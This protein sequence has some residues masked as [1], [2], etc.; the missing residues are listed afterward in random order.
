MNG[1]LQRSMRSSGLD[2]VSLSDRRP[3][4]AKI[5]F[6]L[7]STAFRALLGEPPGGICAPPKSY[8]FPSASEYR[9]WGEDSA[10]RHPLRRLAG[11]KAD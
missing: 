4:T 7:S 1:Y 9:R 10:S 6:P 11:V 5:F 8:S 2:E 3:D